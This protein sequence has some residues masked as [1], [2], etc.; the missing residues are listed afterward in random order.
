MRVVYL[1]EALKDLR[2][3]RVYYRNVFPEGKDSAYR[4][5][6]K[7]IRLL[8]ENPKMGHPTVVSGLREFSIPRMPF[9]LIYRVDGDELRIARVVDQRSNRSRNPL[10]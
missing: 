3:W 6:E 8:C 9:S 1:A 2:W 4:Q 7:T 5:F 10:K